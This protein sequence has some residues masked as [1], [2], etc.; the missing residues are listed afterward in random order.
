MRMLFVGGGTGG[1]T[2]PLI[3]VAESL[4]ERFPKA[5]FFFLG[6][7]R[8]LDDK[9]IEQA[10]FPVVYRT[11]PA[12]KWRRPFSLK[13]IFDFFKTFAG[14]CKALF[15]LS[16]FRPDVV[17]GAGSYAQVPVAYAAYL[18]GIPV[19]IHQPDFRLL[20]STR[21]V[22]PIAQAITVSFS[23]TA[24][25]IGSG[26]G[27]LAKYPKS[28]VHVTG[29]PVRSSVLGGSVGE[30][31]R[32]FALNDRYPTVLV[33]GGGTG[34]R[35]LNEI[36]Q[37]SVPELAKYVQIIHLTGGRGSGKTVKAEHYH[38]YE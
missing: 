3:A 17:F 31:R 20:L 9:F 27:L 13:N 5:E 16:K 21:M 11:I 2:A 26:S 10:A 28:K 12:G 36:I 30:A 29:N 38:P 25:G 37:G 4:R 19:V 7:R 22:A 23:H 18:R 33:M 8:A 24:Q 15:Y 1:P 32:I 6:T 14:F 35:R 34:A